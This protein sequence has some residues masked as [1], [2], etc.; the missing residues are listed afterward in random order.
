[1]IQVWPSGY[2]VLIPALETPPLWAA[3]LP[4]GQLACYHV[5]PDPE[6]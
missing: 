2:S 4:W 6:G 3:G 5:L 1:M